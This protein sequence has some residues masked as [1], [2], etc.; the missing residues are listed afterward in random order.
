M[1]MGVVIGALVA[2]VVM[3]VLRK[4][5]RFRRGRCRRGLFRHRRLY[6]VFEQLDTTPGQEKAIRTAW[7]AFAE[8]A[9]S[10]REDLRKSRHELAQAVRGAELDEGA[11]DAIFAAHDELIG[12][13]RRS[14][15]DGIR[16]VHEVLDER[17]RRRLAE[18]LEARFPLRGRRGPYRERSG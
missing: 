9:R 17:Q 3:V 4:S 5:R 15:K 14:A 16:A 13:L 12:R 11:V 6:R 1:V 8:D 7:L 2:A 18:M 10:A